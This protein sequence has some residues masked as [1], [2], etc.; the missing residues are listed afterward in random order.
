MP[1]APM[2]SPRV[3]GTCLR[4]LPLP[5]LQVCEGLPPQLTLHRQLPHPVPPPARE[6]P[7]LLPAAGQ[8]RSQQRWGG[9]RD[10]EDILT[11]VALPCV[12]FCWGG[13]VPSLLHPHACLRRECAS[14][15]HSPLTRTR[16]CVS[17]PQPTVRLPWPEA[18]LTHL[19]VPVMPASLH[20]KAPRPWD[21]PWVSPVF[22]ERSHRSGGASL[23]GATQPLHGVGAG[24]PRGATSSGRPCCDAALEHVARVHTWSPWRKYSLTFAVRTSLWGDTWGPGT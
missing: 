9:S 4:L 5:P 7:L 15:D 12:H 23:K 10:P 6:S 2:W 13:R 11:Q 22:G 19:C 16:M 20:L 24:P 21:L 14:P 3:L 18:V 17:D 8:G 1:G